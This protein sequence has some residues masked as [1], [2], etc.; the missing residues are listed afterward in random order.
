MKGLGAGAVPT[1]EDREFNM[2]FRSKDQLPTRE[3][4]NQVIFQREVQ[5]HLT[6]LMLLL[7]PT[8]FDW[9]SNS[10]PNMLVNVVGR[11]AEE[12]EAVTGDSLKANPATEA[13]LQASSQPEE[14]LPPLG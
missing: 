14:T 3:E 4:R 1:V 12:Y 6:G 8:N 5:V 11:L 9:Q 7:E 2:P 13:V 10:Y